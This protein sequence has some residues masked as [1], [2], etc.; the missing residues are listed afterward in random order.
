MENV[1][2]SI[3]KFTIAK[4]KRVSPAVVAHGQEGILLPPKFVG[5]T[6]H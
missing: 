3:I 4:L 5:Q 2:A 6:A 1:I